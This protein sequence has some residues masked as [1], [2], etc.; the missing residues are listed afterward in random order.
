[1]IAIWREVG[2]FEITKQRLVDQMRVTWT[3]EWLTKVELEEIR[4]KILIPSD[5]GGKPRN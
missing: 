2:T 4:R 1:M 5:D 3:N